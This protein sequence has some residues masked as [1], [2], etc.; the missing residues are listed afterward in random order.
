[1]TR[2]KFFAIAILIICALSFIYLNSNQATGQVK[3]EAD[4]AILNQMSLA[5]IYNIT[6]DLSSFQT[7]LTGTLECSLAASY[8]WSYLE[9]T[10]NITD[11]KEDAWEYNGTYSSNLVVRVNGT[12]LKDEIVII[13]AHY[14][15]SSL[16]GNA[17]GA[18][19]NAVGVAVCMEVIGLIQKS[20]ALN[21]TVIFLALAGE[22]QAF[23][24]SQ[25]W[26]NM[27]KDDVS[28]IVAVINLDMIGVGTELLIIQNDQSTWLADAILQAS[29]PL[30]I[31]MGKSNSPYPEN[32]RFDHETFWL[33]QIPAVSI[34]EGGGMYSY[35]HTSEDTIDK[36]SF[37]LVEQCASVVL[38][39]ILSLG[40]IKFQ[41]NQL[42]FSI[43]ICCLIG[44]AAVFP[45]LVFRKVN[46][47]LIIRP[48]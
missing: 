13:V 31:T 46:Q 25:A 24:G 16:E 40:T 47:S 33:K 8:I 12:N 3:K 32:T 21:R 43:I 44:L 28:N 29:L 39:S 27:H 4:M 18:N 23:I 11:I 37:S 48:E 38:L 5:R 17:P 36:I 1:M 7:R 30:N 35:Y 41:Y 22:E 10:L 15:S 34:F 14:D 6:K 19:D 45:F 2:Q 26:L 42:L 9:E 20:G